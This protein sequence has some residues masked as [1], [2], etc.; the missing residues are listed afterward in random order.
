MCVFALSVCYF[1]PI[2]AECTQLND[3][4]NCARGIDSFF[5]SSSTDRFLRHIVARF[6]SSCFDSMD[7]R[8]M[9][10][11]SKTILNAFLI[12]SRAESQSVNT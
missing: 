7:D 11:V 12:V 9:S 3:N 5:L 4:C 6:P 1:I 8:L 2:R 10:S